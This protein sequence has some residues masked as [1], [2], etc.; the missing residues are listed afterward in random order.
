MSQG[1]TGNSSFSQST[2]NFQFAIDSTSLGAAKQCPRYYYYSIVRGLQPK[3]ESPHLVFGLHLHAARERYEHNKLAGLTHDDNLDEVLDWSLKQTWNFELNRPW[4]STH[5]KKNRKTLIQTIVWYLDEQAQNDNLETVVLSNGKPAVELSFRFDSGIRMGDESVIFCGHL[6][7][8]AN[9]GLKP[10]IPD[11]KT[12]V[13][14]VNAKW[15]EQFNPG[16]QFSMYMLA[17]KVAFEQSV[18]GMIVDG[19]QVGVTFS[20]FA[21]FFIPR[22]PASMEEWRED[23]EYWIGQLYRWAVNGHWPQNDKS[24]DMFGG[25]VFRRICSKPPHTREQIINADYA[26]RVW[27]PLVSREV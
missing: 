9:L 24:C 27:D 1:A 14:E 15:A 25:C 2:P 18:E 11:I 20:R 4:I 5:E 21:R 16:N 3:S 19:I 13:S 22:D 26:A 17:G 10:Y 23:A 6:D 8:I 7:R 12:S